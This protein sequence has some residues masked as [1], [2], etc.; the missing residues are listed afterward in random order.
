MH[1][2][3]ETAVTVDSYRLFWLLER[4]GGKGVPREVRTQLGYRH[5]SLKYQLQLEAQTACSRGGKISH[6]GIFGEGEI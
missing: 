5:S 2:A 3:C 1:L 6:S 4:N